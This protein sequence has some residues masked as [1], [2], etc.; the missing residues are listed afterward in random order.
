MSPGRAG[1]DLVY[2]IWRK[3]Q[4]LQ[5]DRDGYYAV[6][7]A[8]EMVYSI[9]TAYA[10]LLDFDGCAFGFQLRL[11]RLGLFLVYALLHRLRSAIDQVL[12]FL[13]TQSG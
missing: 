10:R 9:E 7:C 4:T 1:L 12:G 6:G 8:H 5:L 2:I 13:Q 11:H 3:R